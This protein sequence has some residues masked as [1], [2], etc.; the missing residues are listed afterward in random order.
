MGE[1]EENVAALKMMPGSECPYYA[2]LDSTSQVQSAP[3]SSH[4]FYMS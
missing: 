2:H 4:Y 1:T 3:Q